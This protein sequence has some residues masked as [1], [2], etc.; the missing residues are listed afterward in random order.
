M[1][2][3]L[4]NNKISWKVIKELRVTR[5][6]SVKTHP[7]ALVLGAGTSVMGTFSVDMEHPGES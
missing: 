2:N 4:E 3:Y 5:Q 6:N 7:C 1:E